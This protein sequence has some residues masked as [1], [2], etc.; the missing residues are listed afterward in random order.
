LIEGAQHP[1]NRSGLFSHQIVRL[2]KFDEAHPKR[3]RSKKEFG[4]KPKIVRKTSL[5]GT[6]TPH[7]TLLEAKR[8]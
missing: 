4:R 6:I 8:E 2:N 7:R 3:T 1:L 5:L